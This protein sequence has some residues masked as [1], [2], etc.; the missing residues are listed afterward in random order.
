MGSR[1]RPGTL[2]A[3]AGIVALIIAVGL[4]GERIL[5]FV[6]GSFSRNSDVGLTL[7]EEKFVDVL[8]GEWS[9]DFHLTTIE[10]V[11]HNDGVE[12]TQEFRYRIASYLG[13]TPTLH[14]QLIQWQVP[15]VSLTNDEKRI[16]AYILM[17]T[18]A[19][20]SFPT[21]EE[22]KKATELEERT[23]KDA[24]E[25]LYQFSFLDREKKL[26]F[27]PGPYR[28]RE[29]HEERISE[30]FLHY[31]EIE[32]E[33]GRRFNV[34]CVVDALK[35]VFED[36]MGE[37]VVI[38]TFCP[39]SLQKI[40]FTA[41]RGEVTEVVPADAVI[42][43]GG[44][45]PTNLAFARQGQLERWKKEHSEVSTGETYSVDQLLARIQEER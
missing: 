12:Y 29:D 26:K 35:L 9:K 39:Q 10:Q 11:A 15:T 17:R 3:V 33:D 25:I 16:A 27:F 8:L 38:N 41:H 6:S 32:R 40:K 18:K 23:V 4:Y 1:R 19:D 43:L 20:P 42:F 45:C 37:D 31:V 22:I 14:R 28:L 13:Q 24:L 7:E 30:W 2:L 34:Q 44:T 36:F 5:D 21:L